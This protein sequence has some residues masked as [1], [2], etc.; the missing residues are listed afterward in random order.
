MVD[1]LLSNFRGRKNK[2]T[3]WFKEGFGPF[4]LTH[5]LYV[6]AVDKYGSFLYWS[7]VICANL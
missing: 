4:P 1:K 2:F 7:V 6:C 3:A 5:Q